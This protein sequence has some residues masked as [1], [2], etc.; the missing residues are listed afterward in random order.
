MNLTD[1]R[2]LGRSGLIVSPFALG[3]MTFGTQRWGSDETVSEAVFNAY[4][5]AGG[6]FVDT[7]DVYANGRSEEMLGGFIAK[8]SLRDKTVLATKFTFS[9]EEGNPNAG[10][11]GRKNMHRALDSSLKRL[12]TEHRPLLDALLGP[13]LACLL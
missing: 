11:N 1:Y 2:T 4:L 13:N 9:T 3:T 10:G 7:A 6:N 5:E 8:R 12:Q